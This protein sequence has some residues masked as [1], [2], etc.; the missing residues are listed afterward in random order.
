[1]QVGQV[2]CLNNVL[3]TLNTKPRNPK[4]DTNGFI[5][6]IW[7]SPICLR[8]RRPSRN[9]VDY[10]T[11]NSSA[12]ASPLNSLVGLGSQN[13]ETVLPFLKSSIRHY[14]ALTVDGI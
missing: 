11:S 6:R 1:M 4:I 3:I 10:R 5:Q 12:S 14:T 2:K 9:S 13:F 7:R 8:T